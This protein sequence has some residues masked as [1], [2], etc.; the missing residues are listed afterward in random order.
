MSNT[1]QNGGIVLELEDIHTYYGSIHALKGISLARARR[2]DRDP[3]RRERRRQVDDAPLDQRA[4]PS[5]ERP[6]PLRRPRH[7]ERP[8]ARDRAGGHLAVA[9][10]PPPLLAHVGLREPR[11][12]RLP[13]HRPLEPERGL[14][15]RLRALPAPGGASH[16]E[17]GHALRR[18]AADGRDRASADGA[19]EAAPARRAVD[20]ARADLR[21]EDL[22]DRGGDQR[23]GNS[24]PARRAERADGARRG[25]SRLRARDRG[26]S[27]S[28][29][30]RRSCATTSRSGRPTSARAEPTG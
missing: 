15:S 2:R 24:D 30:R 22:R 29:G 17:G 3:D 11:D 20:G 5:S 19:A 16:A 25:E 21:R 12:G 1:A 14:R 10:G 27:R 26:E 4:Q 8:P 6:H 9:R 28:R 18:R 23:A 13:A 7:H